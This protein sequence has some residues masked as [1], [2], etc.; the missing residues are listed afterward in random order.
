MTYINQYYI[1]LLP[2]HKAS[3]LMDEFYGSLKVLLGNQTA[4]TVLYLLS[5]RFHF[6]TMTVHSQKQEVGI[7]PQQSHG[8]ASGF[9]PP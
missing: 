1:T 3:R 9:R 5:V 7:S 6:I 8:V 4:I 2:S